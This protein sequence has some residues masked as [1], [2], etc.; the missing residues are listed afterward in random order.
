MQRTRGTQCHYKKPSSKQV[1]SCGSPG[2][3][4]EGPHHPSNVDRQK[5]RDVLQLGNQLS[6]FAQDTGTRT[7][8]KDQLLSE[9]MASPA[10]YGNQSPRADGRSGPTHYLDTGRGSPGP[11][12][13]I[14]PLHLKG[15]SQ[16]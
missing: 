1:L 6:W 11:F 2:R 14:G 12:G 4:R 13:T 7:V 9:P 16:G 10:N 3:G 5:V 15:L 8:Q